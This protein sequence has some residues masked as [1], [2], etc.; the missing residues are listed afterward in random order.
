MVAIA[1]LDDAQR[2][3]ALRRLHLDLLDG[4]A[5]REGFWPYSLRPVSIR[6]RASPTHAATVGDAACR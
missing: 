2:I 1:G 5:E 4:R 3:P 6:G